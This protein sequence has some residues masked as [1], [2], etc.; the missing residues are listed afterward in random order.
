MDHSGDA[1]ERWIGGKPLIIDM[2]NKKHGVEPKDCRVINA[3]YVILYLYFLN[4]EIFFSY[5]HEHPN[6]DINIEHNRN[7]QYYSYHP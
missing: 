2:E 5:Q 1:V 6:M 3:D 7:K 4:K